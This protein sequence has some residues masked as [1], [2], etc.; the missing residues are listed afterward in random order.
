MRPKCLK[1]REDGR[2]KT[3]E[4][5]KEKDHSARRHNKV[6]TS[7]AKRHRKHQI[8]FSVLD[9]SFKSQRLTPTLRLSDCRPPSSL[10]IAPL[11]CWAFGFFSYIKWE[12][13]QRPKEGESK[14]EWREGG[15]RKSERRRSEGGGRRGRRTK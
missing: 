12:V 5:G 6:E 11:S 1:E 15:L 10:S 4:N 3:S 7:E 8:F 9:S 14:S 2:E 13:K